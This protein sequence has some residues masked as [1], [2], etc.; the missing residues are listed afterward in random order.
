M[1]FIQQTVRT[2]T[3]SDIES[4]PTGQNGVYG[5]FRPNT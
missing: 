3:R 5:L 1:P 4:L 2:F